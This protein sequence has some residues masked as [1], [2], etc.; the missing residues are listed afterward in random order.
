MKKKDYNGYLIMDFIIIGLKLLA[1]LLGHSL[2]LLST[3]LFDVVVI[4]TSFIAFRSK[5]KTTRGRMVGTAF[6]SFIVCLLSILY[7]FITFKIKI[8]K[9]S[10]LI[11]IFLLLCLVL[12]YVT[13]VY[14][15]NVSYSKKEGI[16]GGS[17]K[18]SSVNII[19]Y[20]VV[21]ASVIISKWGS[22]W[23]QL[24]YADRIGATIVSIF[25]IY[26]A[27]R[28]LVRSFKFLEEEQEEKLNGVI[29]EEVNKC[30][31]V[32][33]I[34]KI[35]ILSNGGIRKIDI[36]LKLQ[37]SIGLTDLITFVVTL[38]DFLLKY[39]DFASVNLVKHVNRSGARKNARNSGSTNSKK[40]TKKKS[41]KSKSKKR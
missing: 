31:E 12:N 1:G 16:L 34:T 26:Y 40:S 20:I 9:P 19:M 3:I 8:M 25:T 5:E 11:L 24:R 4:I 17:N 6:Y 38:E 14:K 23:K 22:L 18:N 7:V 27:L 41:A 15:S 36:D 13:T 35:N 33:N 32:K 30:K 37:S 10:L 28:I 21:L 39:C 29:T 2:A